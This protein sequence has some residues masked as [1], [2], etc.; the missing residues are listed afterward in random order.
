VAAVAAM[1]ALLALVILR[2]S[3]L[4]ADDPQAQARGET[5][6]PGAQDHGSHAPA[7]P[8]AMPASP[9]PPP[10]ISAGDD[11]K[12]LPTQILLTPDDP[13]RPIELVYIFWYGCGT[14][15][16]IDPAVEQYSLSLPHD[17]RFVRIPAMF[18][19]NAT[20]MNHARFFYVMDQLGREKDLHGA[21]FA[22]VQDR[23]GSDPSSGH[24]LAGLADFD[25]MA[26]FA[27]RNGIA[28]SDFEAAWNSPETEA[29]FRHALDY[30]NHLD[31]DAVPAMGVNG[32][33]GFAIAQGGVGR[34][35]ETAQKLMADERARLAA[36]GE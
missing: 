36:K 21:I 17:V 14:C 13:A 1:A 19:R 12:A 10:P 8:G 24:A 35:F 2:P 27:E 16:R 15:R 9:A 11:Y 34:F 23:G 3:P 29:R 28:R 33:Y 26:R 25:S 22:E 18:E 31:L 30:I 20:W 4:P 7:A 32:R 5:A 6:Q